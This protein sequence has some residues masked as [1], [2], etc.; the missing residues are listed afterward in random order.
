LNSFLVGARIGPSLDSALFVRGQT[1]YWIQMGTIVE[2]VVTCRHVMILS[3]INN[4]Y[5]FSAVSGL[6]TDIIKEWPVLTE[7]FQDVFEL[8][9]LV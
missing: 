9:Q 6:V 5:D 2:F 4:S 3:I 7:L 8:G 1:S